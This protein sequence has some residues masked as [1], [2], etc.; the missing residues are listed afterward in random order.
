MFYPDLTPWRFY[1]G[2]YHNNN[3]C[4]KL[5]IYYSDDL[6]SV[7]D[8]TIFLVLPQKHNNLLKWIIIGCFLCFALNVASWNMVILRVAFL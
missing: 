4:L 2:L 5:E 7:I 1:C 3:S 6:L 8:D